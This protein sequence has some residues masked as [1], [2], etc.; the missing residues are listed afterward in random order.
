MIIII[1]IVLV[2]VTLNNLFLKFIIYFKTVQDSDNTKSNYY[3]RTNSFCV[4]SDPCT[5]VIIGKILITN[6]H[7][8]NVCEIQNIVKVKQML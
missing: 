6:S 4:N 3:Y 8:H 7:N 1:L 5:N 2:I